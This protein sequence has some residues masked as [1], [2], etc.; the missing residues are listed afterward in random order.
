MSIYV[1]EIVM[2]ETESGRKWIEQNEKKRKV[3]F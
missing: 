2:L 3:Y 1:Y